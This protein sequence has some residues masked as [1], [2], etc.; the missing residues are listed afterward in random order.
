[1]KLSRIPFVV[2]AVAM[3]LAVAACGGGDSSS[4]TTPA[5][6]SVDQGSDTTASESGEDPSSG[7]DDSGGGGLPA[8]GA[9]GTYTINGDSFEAP[10]FQCEVFSSGQEPHP[11]DLSVLAFL[12]GSEG[13]EVEIGHSTRPGPDGPYEATVMFVF[14]SRAGADG[15]EQFEGSAATGPDGQWYLQDDF[16]LANPIPGET[17]TRDGNRITGSLAGVEQDW[18]ETGTEVIDVTFDLEIPAEITEGC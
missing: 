1:M 5:P 10:V 14:H 11:D 6:P 3:L 9:N 7:S 17:F 13:L 2:L 12:G 8:S 18:P 15:L 4:S 16:Q